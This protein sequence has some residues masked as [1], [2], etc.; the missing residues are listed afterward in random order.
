MQHMPNIPSERDEV[1]LRL[2]FK[3]L[4]KHSYVQV[5]C[6]PTQHEVALGF[7]SRLTPTASTSTVTRLARTAG[8]LWA[9]RC[10][11]RDERL[12]LVGH[13]AEGKGRCARK[14]SM[15]S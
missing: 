9:L 1:P 15:P 3:L 10:A 2:I 12:Q 5:V 4:R 14:R 13:P 6:N 11:G 7:V 8:A